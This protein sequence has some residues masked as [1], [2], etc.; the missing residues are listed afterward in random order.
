MKSSADS[1][2][3][4]KKSSSQHPPFMIFWKYQNKEKQKWGEGRG[5]S[6]KTQALKPLLNFIHCLFFYLLLSGLDFTCNKCFS[7]NFAI[8]EKSFEGL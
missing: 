3:F 4:R 5:H 1:P 2:S 7:R 6:M 8:L